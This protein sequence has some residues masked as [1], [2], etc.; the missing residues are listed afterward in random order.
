MPKAMSASGARTIPAV[1]F[2]PATPR[3]AYPIHIQRAPPE[4]APGP[5]GSVSSGWHPAARMTLPK[6]N[7]THLGRSK[8]LLFGAELEVRI[9]LSPAASLRTI[10]TA[11]VF[12]FLGQG[13]C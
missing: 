11:T 5:S 10:G 2:E 9:Q 6:M 8:A 3:A 7:R 13:I 4:S 12:P 1:F